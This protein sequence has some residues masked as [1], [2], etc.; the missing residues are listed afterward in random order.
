MKAARLERLQANVRRRNQLSE[1][2]EAAPNTPIEL[3]QHY[4][5][6]QVAKMWNFHPATIRRLFSNRPGVLKLGSGRYK[7]L[8]IPA[9]CLRDV[10]EELA[11]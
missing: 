10:H 7:T 1:P 11:E 4:S 8:A 6:N 3:D 5:P 9:R 2:V